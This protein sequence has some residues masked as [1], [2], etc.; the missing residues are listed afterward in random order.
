[1]TRIWLKIWTN[2]INKSLSFVL[3]HDWIRRTID[4]KLN[5]IRIDKKLA[6]LA[7]NISSPP[8][9]LIKN[10]ENVNSAILMFKYNKQD[11]SA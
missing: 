10:N 5:K 9:S 8:I 3:I 1:M 6:F 4:Y 11:Y 2:M 7:L